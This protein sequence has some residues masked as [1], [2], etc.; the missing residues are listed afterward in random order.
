[1]SSAPHSLY[2]DNDDLSHLARPGGWF[3]PERRVP[4]GHA[5][6][7]MLEDGRVPLL[8]PF[9][10]LAAMALATTREHVRPCLRELPV[11]GEGSS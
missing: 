7:Q 3:G 1:M 2:L 10:Q 11:A 9:V 8:V 4:R 5:L 6:P